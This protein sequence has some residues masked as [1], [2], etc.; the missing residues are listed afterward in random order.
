MKEGAIVLTPLPQ[1]DGKIKNRPAVVLREMPLF[2][3]F[4]VCGVSTQF[5]NSR[6]ILTS[7]SLA[8]TTIFEPVGY[9]PT[10]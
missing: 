8:A 1:S 6:R 9:S 2:G 4:L 5:T 10:R 3:D 7:G